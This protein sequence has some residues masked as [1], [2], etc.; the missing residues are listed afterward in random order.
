MVLLIYVHIRHRREL[1]SAFQRFNSE[2][3][4]LKKTK[5]TNHTK[6]LYIGGQYSL[7]ITNK[8]INIPS[9]LVMKMYLTEKYPL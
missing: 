5:I 7:N 8:Q 4:I 3:H 9:K 2:K 1:S 6:K